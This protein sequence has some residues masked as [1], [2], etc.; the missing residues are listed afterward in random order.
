M[1]K[2]LSAYAARS[3]PTRTHFDVVEPTTPLPPNTFHRLFIDAG[4]SH[5]AAMVDLLL[6]G[7]PTAV[8]IERSLPVARREQLTRDALISAAPLI[9]GARLGD[10]SRVGEPDV[11][12][13]ASTVAGTPRYAPLDIKTH[14]VLTT[15][16]SG[17]N[18]AEQQLTAVALP[19]DP[20]THAYGRQS[21]ATRR[22]LIQLAHYH[23][24]LATAGFGV[25]G[26]GLVGIIGA[27][28]TAVWFSLDDPIG[29]H[30]ATD[31][32]THNP[33]SVAEIYRHEFALRQAIAADALHNENAATQSR[34][35]P[36]VSNPECPHCPWREHC[37]TLWQARNDV[38]LLPR[39]DRHLWMRLHAAGLDTIDALAAFDLRHSVAGITRTT[40]QG[41]S[42]QARARGG[43]QVAYRRRDVGAIEVPRADVEVD[44]DME[45]VEQGAY[46]WGLYVTDR[47]DNDSIARGYHAFADWNPDAQIAS[48]HA[49]GA[50]WKYLTLLRDTCQTNGLTFVAYCWSEHAENLWL[51]N[52]AKAHG[53][54]DEVEAF[55]GSD[56]WVDLYDV[57]R[58]QLVT[59]RSNGLKTFAPLTGFAWRD[60]QASGDQAIV[61]WQHAVDH[62]T[63]SASRQLW[64]TRLLTY[65]EDDVKATWHVRNWLDVNRNT[66]LSIK[67]RSSEPTQGITSQ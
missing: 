32:T 59:G 23:T 51:R 40:L 36:P 60:Q 65:N 26:Q 58:Q 13:Y 6:R 31:G 33:V 53:V 27:E 8:V 9:V 21:G 41:L 48:H 19:H 61:W 28:Q 39:V 30:D 55:I 1:T 24:L 46:L 16:A 22:T 63:D 47:T 2:A 44:V 34:L 12:V 38:S 25:D 54:A 45:N 4:V 62:T 10:Q 7:T 18:I 42:D 5:E 35:A 56:A 11:L 14:Q 43:S 52:G 15:T 29:R 57:V 37:N 67:S 3:C 20:L 64:Q 50:F 66:L 17:A 49:F